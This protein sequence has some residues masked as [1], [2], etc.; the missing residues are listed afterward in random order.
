MKSLGAAKSI[1]CDGATGTRSRS[2][3]PANSLIFSHFRRHLRLLKPFRNILGLIIAVGWVFL[4]SHCSLV[5]IPG[6]EFL[7]CVADSHESG[8]GSDP[9]KDSGCCPLE[10]GQYQAPR[11][12]ETTPA[13][14]VA[15]LPNPEV[16]T[17]D[18]SLP[19]EVSLGIL[20]TAPPELPKPWQFSLRTAL[21]V[22][23]P[24]LAS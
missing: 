4:T 1:S 20:T 8:D 15:I 14:V 10:S 11:S 7:R 21:P 16:S 23:A 12:E 2:S 22:R 24:S 17:L 19:V 5:A 6:F 18:N 13:V 9:C 3:T